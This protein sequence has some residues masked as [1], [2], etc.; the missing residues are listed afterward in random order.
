VEQANNKLS[1]LKG[2]AGALD[3][4]SSARAAGGFLLGRFDYGGEWGLVEAHI[5]CPFSVIN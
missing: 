4:A 2:N 1:A 3:S 5:R